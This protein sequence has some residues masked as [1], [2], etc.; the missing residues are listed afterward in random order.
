MP[1]TR[2]AAPPSCL[3]RRPWALRWCS[4]RVA[5]RGRPP[6]PTPCC[7]A[8]HAAG[9]GPMPLLPT[10]RCTAAPLTALRRCQPARPLCL[11]EGSGLYT[12]GKRRLEC[13]PQFSASRVGHSSAGGPR[14]ARGPGGVGAHF[15]KVEG[16]SKMSEHTHSSSSSSSSSTAPDGS[17]TCGGGRGSGF[18]V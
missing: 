11:A 1:S 15:L 17:G 5:R 14:P 7:T 8:L 13:L 2:P 6:P 16:R 3:L 18:A 9:P 12:S 10:P 4:R